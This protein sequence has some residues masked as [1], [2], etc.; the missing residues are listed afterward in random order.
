MLRL[1]LLFWEFSKISLFVIGGGYAIIAVADRALSRR[2]WTEDGELLDRLPVFQMVPGLIATH[3]AVYVG[4]K[5]AGRIGAL[6]S[7]LAVAWPSVLIFTFVSAGYDSLPIDAPLCRSAFLGLRSALAGIIAA[8]VIRGWTRNLNDAF[9]YSLAALALA[10]LSL[11]AEVWVVLLC[12]MSAGL[13]ETLLRRHAQP[14]GQ[15]KVFRSSFLPLLLFLKYGA[16]C[17]GGGFVLVP[18]Y[19]EDFVGPSA[20][21]LQVTADEFSNLM[22]LTQMT[23][24]PIGV[25][26]AT[27][28]GFRLAGVA[29]AVL[30]S[31]ALL[32]PGS[33]LAYFAFAS[34]DRFSSSAVVRGVLRGA[35]PASTALMLVALYAFVRMS[36]FDFSNHFSTFA[37]ILVIISATMSLKK[38]L[39]PV[40]IIV[41]CAVA[42]SVARADVAAEVTAERYPDA[43]S[44]VVDTVTKVEYRPDGTYEENEE[45][46]TKILTE[47]GRRAES[48]I[49]LFYSKRYGAAEILYVGA[50]G[51]DGAERAIDVTATMKD[52]TDNSSMGSNIYDPLDRRIVCT[53][54]GLKVGDVVHTK[55]VRRT[56]KSRCENAWADLAVMEWTHPIV[57]AVWEIKAPAALPLKN[58]KIRNP[59]GNVV[60]ESRK[61]EDGSTLHVFTCTNSPQ[62]F[63]EP[64]MPKLYTQ[65]QNVRVS[66]VENWPEVSRWYWNLCLPRLEKTSPEMTNKV[67]EVVKGATTPDERVRALFKFVSQE[68]RYMGLTMEDTSPGYTPHDVDI[69]FANRYG[70]CRD[71][72]VLLVAMLRIAGFEAYPVLINIGAKHDQDVPMPYFNHAIAAVASPGGGYVLMDPTDEN[73]KDLF[74]S[75]ENDMSYLVCCPDGDVLRT[76][77]VQSPDENALRVESRGTLSRDGSLFLE[78]D[79]SF[80]GIN[81]TA[82]RH[83][84]VKKKPEDRVK[85]FERIMKGLVPGADLVKCDIEP[86]DMRDTDSPVRVRLAARLPE[87][88][89]RGATKDVF[90]LPYVS[91]RLGMANFLLSGNTSLEKRRFPLVLTSTAAIEEHATIELGGALDGRPSLPPDERLSEAGFEFSR[92]YSVSNGVLETRRRL[93]ISKVELSPTEYGAV[94]EAI[95]R[96]EA[97]GRR[98]PVFAA[99][100]LSEADVRMILN[101]TEVSIASDREWTV[102]NRIV[103]EI[104]SYDGKKSSAELKFRFNPTVGGVDLVSAVVSNRDGSVSVLTEKE[105]N[106][107]D[108]GWAA[109]APRYPASKLLVAN[110]PSV[111]IG[112]VVSYTVVHTV[113]NAPAPYYGTFSFDSREPL[114]RRF[115]RVNGWSREVVSPRRVPDEPGQPDASLWRDVEIVSSNRFSRID[116]RVEPYRGAEGEPLPFG[117]VTPRSVRDWMARHVKVAGPGIYETPLGLQL[118]DPGTV[119]KERYATRLDYV[120]TMCAVLKGAGYDADVVLAAGDANDPEETRERDMR[121]KPN[122]R[123]FAYALCRVRE[124]SGGFLGFGGE[125]EEA[126]IGTENEYAPLGASV[127]EGS[128]YFD[129]EDCSFG[130][131]TVPKAELSDSSEETTEI[132]VRENGAVDMTIET[133]YRGSSVG[134][135]RKKFAEILPE[136]RSRLHQSLLGAVAQAATAT[137]DLEADI[138]GYPAKRKFSCFIPD[139]ATIEGDT[140]SVRLPPLAASIP[141]FTGRSRQTPFAVAAEDPETET[142]TVRFPPGYVAAEHLPDAFVFADPRDAGRVWLESSTSSR[143]EDGR[144][145]VTVRRRV[146]KRA[147]AWY[148][149][150]FIELVRDRSRI[151]ASRANRT[152]S[153]R[154]LSKTKT[155]D[156]K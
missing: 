142:V 134:P 121:G 136:D 81:D 101:S 50:K 97:A 103:K 83:G 38:K 70:V 27:Y 67:A 12:A 76:S 35:R 132:D 84:L 112:S 42:A 107:M 47:K 57:R 149:P 86:K 13:A 63:P 53:V 138:E 17:F 127:F 116:L 20:A 74:P 100:G 64:D 28:F 141:T 99:D 88:V 125:V 62:A 148:P 108:C 118:T 29:G 32:L 150:D 90:T 54:P 137:S 7:V 34:L 91:S 135:F 115:V 21:F 92:S 58:V 51:P 16:L 25:N 30:A 89:L 77:P 18:M 146:M 26:G 61:L 85:V 48:S 130:V 14:G 122:V 106:V 145:A 119:L 128:N 133:L 155:E 73:A 56:F 78:S 75:Y 22:A 43:D 95:K 9:S 120:R 98:Q 71:K 69:T 93:A 49:S 1:A 23:P 5:V 39:N 41:L 10:A 36:V 94:R 87:T 152:V 19:I 55:V 129:P 45:T 59:L 151:A 3:T 117:E 111:E 4:R 80:L 6:V 143:T 66:T 140:V 153:A 24:G 139:Y 82:Y 113:T 8:A 104:L 109:S 37:S 52:A 131:V 65:V 110:L 96:V 114:D 11:G 105:K 46:W 44:V 124:R 79:I 126:F 72:A 102:T 147:S 154:R 40:L 68:I 33:V 123:A 144:L 31:A 60:S 2:G 15:A 156:E